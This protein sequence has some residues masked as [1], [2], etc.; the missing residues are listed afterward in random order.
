MDN[1]RSVFELKMQ[2]SEGSKKDRK[3]VLLDPF[4]AMGH[5]NAF[6][7]LA[8]WLRRQG[9][10]PVFLISYEYEEKVWK[11]GKGT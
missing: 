5:V 3:T 8:E 9:F 4:P 10:S 1:E 2:K 11:T 7:N 6:L